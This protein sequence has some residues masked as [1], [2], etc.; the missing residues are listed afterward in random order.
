MANYSQHPPYGLPFPPP[1]PQAQPP[2]HQS[3]AAPPDQRQSSV[4]ENFHFN[5]G[6][7]GLNLQQFAQNIPPHHQYQYWPPPPPPPAPP[8]SSYA[9][10]PF[11]PP[12][13]T[14][15]G[16]LPPP[17]PPAFFPP[18]PQLP[19]HNAPTPA[20]PSAAPF[21]PIR[22]AEMLESE[23][24]DGEV[25]D[26]GPVSVSPTGKQ[27]AQLAPARSVPGLTFDGPSNGRGGNGRMGS[28]S[29]PPAGNLD[30]RGPPPHQQPPPGVDNLSQQRELAKEFIALLH[31]HQI[32]Y[33]ALAAEGLDL[34]MLN[35]MFSSMNLPSQPTHSQTTIETP[36]RSG[37]ATNGMSLSGSTSNDIHTQPKAPPAIK[38]NVKPTASSKSVPSPLERSQPRDRASYIALLQASRTK[39]GP[40]PAQA[41]ASQQVSKTLSPQLPSGAATPTGQPS[42]TAPGTPSSGLAAGATNPKERALEDEKVRKTE[43]ARQRLEAFKAKRAASAALQAQKS[44]ANSTP[45]LS[46]VPTN[47]SQMVNQTAQS[48]SSDPHPL[49]TQSFSNIPGL[50]MSSPASA[51]QALSRQAKTP[52][53]DPTNAGT[54]RKRPLASDFD[55]IT[56]PRSSA[57]F[58]DRSFGQSPHGQNADSMIIQVSEDEG[59]EMDLDDDQDIQP[60]RNG[61]SSLGHKQTGQQH[62]APNVPPLSSAP[63]RSA[64]ARPTS[65]LGTPP[66]GTASVRDT[67]EHLQSHEAKIN[68]MKRQIEAMENKKKSI[69]SKLPQSTSSGS[70]TSPNGQG[71][72]QQVSAPEYTLHPRVLQASPAMIDRTPIGSSW[73]KRRRV[74]IGSTLDTLSAEM[75]ASKNRLVQLT[76]QKDALEQE[77]MRLDMN[78]DTPPDTNPETGTGAVTSRIETKNAGQSEFSELDENM[79]EAE[80]SGATVVQLGTKDPV[81][82]SSTTT[83]RWDSAA[84][85]SM[86]ATQPP[87]NEL[88]VDGLTRLSEMQSQ[89]VSTPSPI[90]DY[91]PPEPET[92]TARGAESALPAPAGN[93]EHYNRAAT[94]V[95]DE[96][97]FYS[98]APHAS[99][100]P[101]RVSEAPIASKT[102]GQSPSEEGEV[103]M[104]ES[105][106]SPEEE[107]YEPSEHDFAIDAA[108]PAAEEVAMELESPTVSSHQSISSTPWNEEQLYEPREPNQ[109]EPLVP[110][111]GPMHQVD[112]A[113]DQSLGDDDLGGMD[114]SSSSDESDSGSSSS[115]V[116]NSISISKHSPGLSAA[117]AEDLSVEAQSQSD[118]PRSGL[119]TEQSPV[120]PAPTNARFVPYESPL[121]MFK[122]Y[123]YHPNYSQDVA[124]G[125]LST[126]YSHQID[127]DKPICPYE[128]AGDVCNDAQCGGQ[129]FKDMSITGDKLLVQLGTANP[130]K[131]PEEKHQWNAGL[132]LVLKE[133]RQKN[134]KN[135]NGIA[136]EISRYRRQFLN[137]DTR[138]INL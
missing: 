92:Y 94:P 66:N 120:E 105:A 113:G 87:P 88:P 38:T 50:F 102:D 79:A 91:V 114:I 60:E 33:S 119:L 134:I 80:L 39:T 130:G 32:G 36:E 90:E 124:G 57:A 63:S 7:P 23:K 67:M 37:A 20:Q 126:S 17:P 18:V 107:E 56:T 51:T 106:E 34:G 93:T 132:R 49:P 77:L 19:A 53:L 45:A 9:Q 103:I 44:A 11:P 110:N 82:Q 133:L 122:S 47:D 48:A 135:P 52:Q 125:F 101:E 13:L 15:N 28:H 41:T 69:A 84:R 5:G 27:K 85:N 29:G 73:R 98:P 46:P 96:E 74:E 64:S 24:E 81:A 4:A 115:A 138:V 89:Q 61:V 1:P 137:D 22:L 75:E 108:V 14:P 118:A 62:G 111:I 3:P 8:S 30:A 95:D 68:M 131:T 136:Q 71:L 86:F 2:P 100:G 31:Q 58:H 112:S 97:D 121:R 129:H 83:S 76:Q 72:A 21:Q 123:R 10:P 104:S 127:P 6:L 99:I 59:S 70:S 42:G 16:V 12:F 40:A 43:L 54:V 117:A 116:D 25:S 128:A 109:A 55:E 65:A 35:A 26:T 78:I